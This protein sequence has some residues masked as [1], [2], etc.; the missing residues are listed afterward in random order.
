VAVKLAAALGP[1]TGICRTAGDVV[2]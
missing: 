1:V 2:P